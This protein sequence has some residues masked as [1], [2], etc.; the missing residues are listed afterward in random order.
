M[1][2]HT[3]GIIAGKFQ[4]A[5]CL[6]EKAYKKELRRLNVDNA[7]HAF[8]PGSDATVYYFDKENG[9]TIAVLC[10]SLLSD[11]LSIVGLL[12]HEAYHIHRY[13][14]QLI[15]EESPGE[16]VSAYCLQMILQTLLDELADVKLKFRMV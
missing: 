2:Y 11:H 7:D 10:M 12:A 6:S 14:M 1:I 5:V 8:L 13:N 9:Q 3:E 4:Y 15:R 16:E